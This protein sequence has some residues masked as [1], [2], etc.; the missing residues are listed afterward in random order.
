MAATAIATPTAG[1]DDGAGPQRGRACRLWGSEATRNTASPRAVI[2]TARSSV[3]EGIRRLSAA[4][5]GTAQTMPLTT[6]GCTTAIGP[7]CSALAWST[8]AQVARNCP[9]SHGG[10]RTR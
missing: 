7:A 10:R 3:S 2:T 4:R 1:E 9:T 8:N 6:M 5:A